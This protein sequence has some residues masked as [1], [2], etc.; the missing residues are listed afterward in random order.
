MITVPAGI[1]VLV[2]TKPVDFR[3]GADSLAALVR[4]QL[5][6]DPFS[7]TIYIFRSKRA[8]RLKILA[9]GWVRPGA[10]L[11]AARARS[12]PL[13]TDQRWCDA[14]VRIA[15]RRT[16]RWHGLVAALRPRYCAADSDVVST[17]TF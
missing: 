16:R 4:E 2:A 14:A 11:E 6:H 3:R 10:V 9:L 8:D 15:A 1:R 13:A 17:A 7:G 5:K 12:L